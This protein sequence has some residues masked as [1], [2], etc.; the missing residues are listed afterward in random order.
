MLIATL[1][2]LTAAVLHAGWNLIAKRAVDP[3]L[4]LWGQFL[5]AA[6]GSGVVLAVIGPPPLGAWGWAAASGLIHVPYIGGLAWAYRHGDFSLAYP[7]ARG[8]GAL[9]AAIGG[10]LLLGDDLSALSIVAVA[11]VV[12]GMSLLA[13][14]APPWQ[15]AIA[16]GVALTIGSY[17]VVDSHAA[18]EYGGTAYVFAAFVMMGAC[19][20]AAGV[21]MGRA[22]ELL[23]L[24]S[25]FWARTLL[26]A[27]MSVVTY[28]LVLLAV[29]RAA[30]G[31]VA[32]LR[33][34]SVLIA[35]LIG[36]R[37]L[38]EGRGRIRAVAA[39]VIVGGLVLLVASR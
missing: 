4:A 29:R 24:R 9:V 6:A 13:I 36:W 33:E 25:G 34:S 12:G 7:V 11:I 14:G 26:A 17:T 8:G 18:R 5:A 35:A 16:V 20:T 27:A 23:T 30:V 37:W 38:G 21:A 22:R 1:Y 10:V 3:F 39:A 15:L 31:Y 28:G 32:A 19:I 2:A